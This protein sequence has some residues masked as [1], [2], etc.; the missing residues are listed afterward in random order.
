M[1]SASSKIYRVNLGKRQIFPE[2]GHQEIICSCNYIHNP[3]IG[4]V[5]ENK[6]KYNID[7]LHMAG[8]N[9][10]PFSRVGRLR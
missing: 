1:T 5:N 6:K 2:S 8:G 10:Q 4:M 7:Y 9:G 3:G